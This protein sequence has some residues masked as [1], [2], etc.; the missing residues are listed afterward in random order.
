MVQLFFPGI[1]AQVFVYRDDQGIHYGEEMKDKVFGVFVFQKYFKFW[2][3]SLSHF[4][5]HEPPSL[6]SEYVVY[7]FLHFVPI[8]RFWYDDEDMK[9]GC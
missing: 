3:V 5:K 6:I 8:S 1:N 2:S 9:N 7:L 4:I